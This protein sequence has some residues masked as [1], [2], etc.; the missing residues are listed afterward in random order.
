ML[1][2]GLCFHKSHPNLF[3]LNITLLWHS[4]CHQTAIYGLNSLCLVNIKDILASSLCAFLPCFIEL[5]SSFISNIRSCFHLIVSVWQLLHLL[6]A[7]PCPSPETFILEPAASEQLCTLISRFPRCLCV[8]SLWIATIKTASASLPFFFHPLVPL[9]ILL[10]G[11]L[12][13]CSASKPVTESNR[14]QRS[15]SE[16]KVNGWLFEHIL[17]V[18]GGQG[19]GKAQRWCVFSALLR[20]MLTGFVHLFTDSFTM[21]VS[22]LLYLCA[23][24]ICLCFCEF[25]CCG[26]PELLL[27]W[28]H[29]RRVFFF[30]HK[31]MVFIRAGMLVTLY[32]PRDWECERSTS[33]GC[34]LII[35]SSRL[36]INQLLMAEIQHRGQTQGKK[37]MK[38]LM[39]GKENGALEGQNKSAESKR[40]TKRKVKRMGRNNADRLLN[41]LI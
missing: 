2:I 29:Y 18:G 11:W 26:V 33:C 35:C 12:P 21:L 22:R 15:L 1:L 6:S 27:G 37:R 23:D 7:S 39:R 24:L 36:Q 28:S 13:A 38:R 14:L 30:T 25:I 17:E 19:G 20:K 10:A 32:V 41:K 34:R 4:L 40:E 9:C 8:H 31:Q 5:L 3:C 16:S